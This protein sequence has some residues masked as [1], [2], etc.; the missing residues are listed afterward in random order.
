LLY[1]RSFESNPLGESRM[2][3]LSHDLPNVLSRVV[4]RANPGAGQ[5]PGLGT[6]GIDG[7]RRGSDFQKSERASG[8]RR[9]FKASPRRF[10]GSRRSPKSQRPG[11]DADRRV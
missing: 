10:F 3:Y 1:G 4:T 9:S 2:R 7:D 5:P 6:P 8:A 11:D